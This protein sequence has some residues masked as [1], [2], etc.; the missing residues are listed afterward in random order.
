M[1]KKYKYGFTASCFDLL[2]FGHIIM[3]KEAKNHCDYLIVGLQQDPSIDRPEK[4]KPVQTLQERL[5]V[6]KAIKYVD[7]IIIYNTEYDLL[8]LLQRLLASRKLDIRFLGDDW[9]G[10]KYTGWELP[11]KIH[12]NKRSSH[13]WSSTK[14]RSLI[15]DGKM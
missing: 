8:N 11:V 9:R 10:K 3:L 14:M 4:H 1:V 6:L 15:A 13:N 7:E 12:F 5:E 2:H